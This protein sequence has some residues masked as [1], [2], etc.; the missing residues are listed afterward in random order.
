MIHPYKSLPR[1]GSI[2]FK[3]TLQPPH[4]LFPQFHLVRMLCIYLNRMAQLLMYNL[5][6]LGALQRGVIHAEPPLRIIN[7]GMDQVVDL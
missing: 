1:I 7:F 5:S 4:Y 3:S 2:A 6:S